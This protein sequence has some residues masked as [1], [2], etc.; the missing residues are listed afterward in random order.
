M[1]ADWW[2]VQTKGLW[3]CHIPYRYYICVTFVVFQV[4]FHDIS[5]SYP[6]DSD[7]CC[8]YSLTA[9]VEV[10][11]GDFVAVFRVGWNALDEAVLKHPAYLPDNLPSS[12][13]RFDVVKLWCSV[14]IWFLHVNTTLFFFFFFFMLEY[15]NKARSSFIP[16][17]CPP[18]RWARIL[19][20][21]LR[22]C[23]WVCLW[24]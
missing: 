18:E 8:R 24:C 12:L 13:V 16:S 19:S 11:E 2:Q 3:W 4:V 10:Q 15:V 17:W 5:D 9:G 1:L 21:M 6:T 14:F 22:H 7:V 20:A 23:K